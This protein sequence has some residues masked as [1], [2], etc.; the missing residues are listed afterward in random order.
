M[1]GK[2]KYIT[3]KEVAEITSLALSTLRNE[4]FLGKG[5]PYYKKGKSVR[6]KYEDV[7]EFME[8]R[9]VETYQ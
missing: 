7:I 2:E 9:R 1:N 4:R 3:E 8:L 6:Y 5:I